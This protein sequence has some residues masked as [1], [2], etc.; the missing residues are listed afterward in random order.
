MGKRIRRIV[1]GRDGKNGKV[2]FGKKNERKE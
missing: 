1:G 2:G